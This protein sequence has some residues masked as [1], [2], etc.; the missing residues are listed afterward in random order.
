MLPQQLEH[1]LLS[2]AMEPQQ[3]LEHMLH[4]VMLQVVLTL[5]TLLVLFMLLREML[6]LES[7]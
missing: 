4:M 7:D 3:L 1:L 2:V 6:K 5:L